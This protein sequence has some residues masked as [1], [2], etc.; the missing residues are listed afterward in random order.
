MKISMPQRAIRLMNSAFMTLLLI[1]HATGLVQHAIEQYVHHPI[2]ETITF[3]RK[4]C[5]RKMLQNALRLEK[6]CIGAHQQERAKGGIQ[7]VSQNTC[8]LSRAQ[9]GYHPAKDIPHHLVG[10]FFTFYLI[11]RKRLAKK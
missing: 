1:R 3:T 5:L 11:A 8:F 4:S 7:L 10:H 6:E 9:Y 2:T